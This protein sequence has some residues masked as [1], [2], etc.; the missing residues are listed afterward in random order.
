MAASHSVGPSCTESEY[1]QAILADVGMKR[2]HARQL[3]SLLQRTEFD[4][5][6]QTVR[7]LPQTTVQED[8]DSGDVSAWN[9]VLAE[10]DDSSS[11]DDAH[12]NRGAVDE[13]PTKMISPIARRSRPS[14]FALENS[15]LASFLEPTE[16]YVVPVGMSSGCGL[17]R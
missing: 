11:S 13:K 4:D 5:E 12:L 6:T 17:C 15:P 3:T 14:P 2:G 7:Q 10:V 9:T 8:Q 1:Q 16:A